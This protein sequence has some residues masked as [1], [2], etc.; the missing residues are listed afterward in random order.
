MAVEEA[1][2]RRRGIPSPTQ[3]ARARQGKACSSCVES[4]RAGWT[5]FSPVFNSYLG[6][7]GTQEMSLLSGL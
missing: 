7:A 5:A 1:V 2:G 4:H 6:T 3:T